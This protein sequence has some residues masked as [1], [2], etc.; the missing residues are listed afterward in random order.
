MRLESKHTGSDLYELARNIFPIYRSITGD[1]VRTTLKY[2]KKIIP[3]MQIH[4][5]ASGTRVYDWTVPKEWNISEAYIENNRR[6]KIIDFKKNNLHV[7]GYSCPIDKWVS[8]EEL[9][10]YIYTQPDQPDVIPYITS[11]YSLRSG[12]CMSK[13][14]WN[15]L[16]DG[17]YHMYIDS[18]FTDGSMTYG[19][20]IIPGVTS[21]EICFSTNICHPGLGS[22]E[23]SGPCVLT[24]LA[25]WLSEEPNRRYTYRFLFIPETI[26]SITYISQHLEE[27]KKN[28][29]AGF[30]V[31]CVGDDLEY[32]YVES[33]KG[34]TLADRALQQVL[35]YYAPMYKKYSFLKRGSD[36]RQ[37]CAPGVDLPFVVFCRSKYHEYK[38][39]H[40]SADNLSFISSAGMGN[41][42]EV[43]K[44]VVM[45]LEYNQYYRTTVLCEPQLG[46]RGLY[47]TISQK[48]T[49]KNNV[50][51][52]Q[53]ILAYADGMSDLIEISNSINEPIEELAKTIDIL[54]AEGLVK[55]I[56]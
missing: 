13:D 23:V 39:Y 17:S 29:K 8:K 28:I 21:E 1:G 6:E 3:D 30:V 22:N 32:S 38:E 7:V 50:R 37:Y 55:V 14:M 9:K 18:K 54:I 19:E 47:P 34:G 41:A 24:Y 42:L 36:E 40:T 51:V 25:K 4:E 5:V 31:T 15:D 12:F 26:G 2:L 43:L 49:Y 20:I 44:R 16:P 56:G 27:M 10:Q 11:Y 52:I 48:G 33:R 53:N 46:K 45:T 35:K